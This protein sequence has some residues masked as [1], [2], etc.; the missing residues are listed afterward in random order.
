MSAARRLQPRQVLGLVL[1]S[2]VLVIALEIAVAV[3]VSRVIGP[4]PTLLLIVA[5][6]FAGLMLVRRGGV[7]SILALQ[8]AAAARRL[9]GGEMADAVMLMIGGVLMIPPGFILD[10]VGLL[11]VLPFTRPL[12]RRLAGLFLRIRLVSQ[13][14]DSWPGRGTVIQG[15]IVP[16]EDELGPGPTP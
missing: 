13:V 9:P 8:Q 1:L 12:V 7:R 5:F 4:W 6:S 15:E 11:F 3:L 2:F 10:L 14:A 16:D